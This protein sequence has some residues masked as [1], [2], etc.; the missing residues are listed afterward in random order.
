MLYTRRRRRRRDPRIVKVMALTRS[1][2]RGC[3]RYVRRAQYTTVIYYYTLYYGRHNMRVIYII[4]HLYVYIFFITCC[5]T[6]IAGGRRWWKCEEIAGCSRWRHPYG[7]FEPKGCSPKTIKLCTYNSIVPKE[8]WINVHFLGKYLY[9]T[10]LE[11]FFLDNLLYSHVIHYKTTF[12]EKHCIF[13][14][15]QI[16][17]SA[18]LFWL[19]FNYFIFCKRIFFWQFRCIKIE[20]LTKYR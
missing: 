1:G 6:A 12:F 5:V 19:L 2:C 17:L 7:R 20:F 13:F 15:I 18:T 3:A 10:L 9:L 4:M 11:I 8:L 16:F 14:Y